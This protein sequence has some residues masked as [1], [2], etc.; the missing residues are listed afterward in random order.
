ML[1]GGQG[2]DYC[3]A[4]AGVP[5]PVG[6]C[7]PHPGWKGQQYL[8]VALLVASED[9]TGSD[10]ASSPLGGGENPVSTTPLTPPK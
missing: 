3:W 7:R 4:G 2:F 10:M 6:L 1:R 5:D 8:A 9:P